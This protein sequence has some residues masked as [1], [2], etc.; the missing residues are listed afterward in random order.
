MW[1]ALG[2]NWT[3]LTPYFSYLGMGFIVV[4]TIISAFIYFKNEGNQRY[5]QTG[6]FLMFATFMLSVKMHDRYA[7]PVMA[8][9]IFAFIISGK[10]EHFG[11]F[12]LVSLS[13]FFN[14]AWILFVYEQ[15]PA[16]YIDS[17]VIIVASVINLLIFAFMTVRF[18]KIKVSK[19]PVLP[20]YKTGRLTKRDTYI[21]CGIAL[22][23]SVFAFSNLGVFDAPKT[24]LELKQGEEVLITATDEVYVDSISFY[25]G[26]ENIEEDMYINYYCDG[27]MVFEDVAEEGDAFFWNERE[28]G[29]F[30]DTV[31]VTTTKESLELFEIV[32]TDDD[33]EIIPVSCNFDELTD[34]QELMPERVTFKNSAYFDEIY[35]ARTAYE[36]VEGKE[37]YEWTHPP[38]GKV[39][40]ALGV[41]IFGMNP[42]GW[43][44]VGTIFGVLMVFLIY[45]LA[46]RIFKETL[47]ATVGC[48]M[49]SFDF[50][51]FTQTRI[52]TI[53]V[54]V[55]FFIMFMYYFMYKY[56]AQDFN[57]VSLKES[58]K[59]LLLAGVSFGLG[60]ASKWTAMYACAGL[61]LIFVIT[62]IRRFIEKKEGFLSWFFKTCGFCVL[63][64]ILIPVLIYVI[65]YIP[66]LRANGDFSFSAIWQNQVDML[67]YHGDT[68]VGS[69]H[70]FASPWFSWPILYRPMW[71][72]EGMVS[73]SIKEG[74]S[75]FGNPLVW[76]L[77]IPS[78]FVS[79]YYAIIQ[80]NKQA[81]FLVIGYL[82]CLLPWVFVER[83]T[84]IYHYFPCVVFSVLM[85]C[86]VL[87]QFEYK[88]KK[89]AGIALC[90]GVLILFLMFYPV[91]S[92]ASVAEVYVDEV[93]RW[94]KD[95]WVLIG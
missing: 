2:Q 26:A 85:T 77:G 66:Y 56:Y 12:S 30:A 48:V 4:I 42:F 86:F 34:E 84:Y 17:P 87:S 49:F 29:I 40:I 18:S 25:P 14:Q 54:Y 55:T 28:V 31:T 11:L 39:F 74:I 64:F 6:A 62:V 43:R 37:V 15:D 23:Y 59:P 94:M 8:M 50:M 67:T 3:D 73:E 16:C 68:V 93:L 10:K 1:G 63:V 76:W 91:L 83:T 58:F 19:E 89:Y 92:G 41:K 52:A 46:K 81:G 80:R 72:Y 38:L 35:H 24:K 53:D 7:Y 27:D 71:Y 82:S 75:A 70:P 13:Q 47:I 69:D 5:F 65:S 9:L 33:G 36:F 57:K 79:L 61:A 45:A 60:V 22:L 32:L 90:T 20:E 21:M 78:F 44:I 88:T 51:H 95:S